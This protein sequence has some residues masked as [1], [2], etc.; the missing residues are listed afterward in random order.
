MS[1]FGDKLISAG[2]SLAGVVQEKIAKET[3]EKASK[4]VQEFN[5][6]TFKRENRAKALEAKTD[7]TT[8]ERI[9]LRIHPNGFTFDHGQLLS[10]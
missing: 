5:V 9:E 1:K 8:E 10:S 6:D 7:I 4:I 3:G 2:K